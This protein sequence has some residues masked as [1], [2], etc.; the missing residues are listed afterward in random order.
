MMPSLRI[1]V[2]PLATSMIYQEHSL[3]E[4]Q[5]EKGGGVRRAERKKGRKK[6]RK[7]GRAVRWKESRKGRK[8]GGRK[9]GR[10]FR[11]FF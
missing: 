9:E 2:I 1:A 11:V 4:T 3:S 7:T 6:R 5:S 8:E 10:K